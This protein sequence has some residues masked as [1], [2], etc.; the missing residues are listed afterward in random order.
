M[1]DTD[2][3]LIEK[4]IY[5][6]YDEVMKAFDDCIKNKRN[7]SNAVHFTINKIENLI[8]LCD[9]VNNVTYEIGTSITFIV[10]FPVYREVFAADFRDRVI[11]HLVMK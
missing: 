4:G 3:K 7:S 5:F 6:T 9:D 11:H 2:K 8:A 1:T 10:K